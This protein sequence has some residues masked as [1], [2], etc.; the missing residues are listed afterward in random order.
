MT[1]P[2]DRVPAP[3][4]PT[5]SATSCPTCPASFRHPARA[6]P[7]RN[8]FVLRRTS[9]F[10]SFI[11]R[12]NWVRFVIFP[13]SP[14]SRVSSHPPPLR[15]TICKCRSAIAAHCLSPCVSL[16]AQPFDTSLYRAMRWR[17]IGPFR[18]GPRDRGGGHPGQR[19]HL[20]HGHARRRPLEDR[21]RRRGL[22]AHLRFACPSLPS[23]RWPW[24]SP[25][26][27]SFTS[28]PATSAWWAA[29]ST[30]AT[31]CTNPST[32]ARR[33]STSGSTRPNT[34]ATCGWTRTIP[35]SCWWRRW[36][37]RIRRT[38]SA[39]FS[40]PPTAARP[41]ATFCIRTTSPARWTWC[42]RPTIR[43][44]ATPRCGNT[45]RA[46]GGRGGHRI[47][48]LRGHLQDHRRRRHLDATHRGPADADGWAAS[49]WR[50][51]RAGRRSSPSSLAAADSVA[52]E[53][54]AAVA[55]GSTA[56]TTAARTGARA[57]RIRAFTGSGYFSR[58]FLDPKNSD[59]VY[60]AQTS[61]Y[62]SD[63][64]RPH[65]QLVQRRAGRRRQPRPVDRPD[66]FATA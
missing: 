62:R 37:A 15:R 34:S 17:Q 45:T 14:S 55:A 58:V 48:G 13:F 18:A 60:V 64:R 46:P 2:A 3:P 6:I 35:T 40:R 7:A 29:R 32:P 12:Q 57:R 52:A 36:A 44:S 50:W 19:R 4:G 47:G 21:R 49:A 39:A 5:P 16:A 59:V 26:P 30:W 24:R 1:H 41:G 38:I 9:S 61:L 11:C 54:A 25:I 31:A 27:I 8:G 22:D 28:A 10:V 63:G 20:L 42:S 23:A 33:G 53:E 66:R 56:P 65:V 51:R 43:R